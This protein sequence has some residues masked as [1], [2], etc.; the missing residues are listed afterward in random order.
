MTQ[1]T[2]NLEKSSFVFAFLLD[3]SKEE[4]IRE[5]VIACNT[6]E[7]KESHHLRCFRIQ[8]FNKGRGGIQ[9]QTRQH[10]NTVSDRC[11]NHSLFTPDSFF[12]TNRYT[13]SV[14]RIRFHESIFG[15]CFLFGVGTLQARRAQS[16]SFCSCVWQA[17]TAHQSIRSRKYEFDGNIVAFTTETNGKITTELEREEEPEEHGMTVC[18]KTINGKTISIKCDKEHKAHTVSEKV[19]M[20]TSIFGGMTYLVHHGKVLN[21][22]KM[23]KENNIGPETTM[24]M[25]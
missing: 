24:E 19:K 6:K 25:S 22:K 1:E 3:R 21:D 17:Q 15:M 8:K 11:L 18:V 13:S 16:V 5:V 14:C 7:W 23:I 20:N 4:E 9:G 12:G 2:E 10:S